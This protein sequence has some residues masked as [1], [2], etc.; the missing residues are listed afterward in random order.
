[1]EIVIIIEK[2]YSLVTFQAILGETNDV[3]FMFFFKKPVHKWRS[4]VDIVEIVNNEKKA[5][6]KFSK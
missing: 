4:M 2:F 5:H 3:D 1:M 6:Y